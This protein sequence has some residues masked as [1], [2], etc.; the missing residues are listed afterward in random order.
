MWA[1]YAYGIAYYYA[2]HYDNTKHSMI[3]AMLIVVFTIMHIIRLIVMHI[4]K[5]MTYTN[6]T[7]TKAHTT[8]I[9]TQTQLRHK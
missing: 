8:N 3:I 1:Y 9:H 5:R 4:M 7:N 6:H 2:C